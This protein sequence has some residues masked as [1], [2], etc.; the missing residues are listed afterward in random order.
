MSTLHLNRVVLQFAQAILKN[1]RNTFICGTYTCTKLEI[2][3]NNS[4]MLSES[5]LSTSEVGTGQFPRQ[6]RLKLSVSSSVLQAILVPVSALPQ[7]AKFAHCILKFSN[8]YT[9]TQEAAIHGF[10]HA[11]IHPSF[12]NSSIKGSYNKSY[13]TS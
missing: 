6:P 13:S 4:Q 11:R 12:S 5:S 9:S 7:P 8:H 1:I 2:C 10:K 3:I